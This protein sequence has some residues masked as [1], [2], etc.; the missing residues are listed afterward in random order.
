MIQFNKLFVIIVYRYLFLGRRSNPP[1][2]LTDAH[3]VQVSKELT[4]RGDLNKLAYRGLKLEPSE[5]ES[6]ITNAPNDIQTAAYSVLR[7]W[8]KQQ[9]HREETYTDLKEALAECNMKMLVSK[10]TEW[11]EEPHL[12]LELTPERM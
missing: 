1:W 5:V 2:I 3:V 8:M 6:A 9:E 10:L 7:E 4:T 12:S 11:V